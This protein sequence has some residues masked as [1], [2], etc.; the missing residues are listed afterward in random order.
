M[1][2]ALVTSLLHR[3]F[4][5]APDGEPQIDGH[6]RCLGVE[7]V[8]PVENRPDSVR[9]RPDVKA[10]DVAADV[11]PDAKERRE[12]R[13]PVDHALT[14][15]RSRATSVNDMSVPWSSTSF[16]VAPSQRRMAT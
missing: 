14:A 3:P 6:E 7:I 16:P 1:R 9:H 12:G 5:D 8:R 11:E 13:E 4:P 10:G 15:L 2:F